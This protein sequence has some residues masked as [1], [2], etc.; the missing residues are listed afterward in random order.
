MRR[1]RI[2]STLIL[3]L[4][5]VLAGPSWLAWNA[6]RERPWDART[7]RI[8]FDSV[9]F[10]R[11]GLVFTYVVENRT[12]RDA[13][14]IPGRAEIKAVQEEDLPT[15]GY[16][17]LALPLEFPA[18]Q[19]QRVEIRLELPAPQSWGSSNGK[20]ARAALQNNPGDPKAPF[21]L[22]PQAEP[23]PQ[24]RAR[25][26][27]ESLRYLDGFDLIDAARGVKIRFPRGW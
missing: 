23:E 27:A 13:K 22:P 3:G 17:N 12:W 4:A 1:L 16:P 26:A 25:T 14:F 20:D 2:A 15:A 9:R 21:G 11:A 8:R 10:D 24:P 6:F 7:L 19:E 5:A 18:H